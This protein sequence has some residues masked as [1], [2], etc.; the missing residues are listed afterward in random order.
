LRVNSIEQAKI[1][2]IVKRYAV[3][4]DVYLFGS[5]VYDHKKG[6]D[7][8]ILVLDEKALDFSTK[9]D[10]LTDLNCEICE[11]KYDVVSFTLESN[12]PFKNHILQ[13][14]IKLSSADIN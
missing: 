1:V 8:D 6:G 7:I 3:N 2:E 12:E 4:A 10:I 9:L 13:H 14:A 11:Q 5:R